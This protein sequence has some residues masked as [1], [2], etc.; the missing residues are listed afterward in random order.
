MRALDEVS[1]DL[2][3]MGN[4]HKSSLYMSFSKYS[5]YQILKQKQ[6]EKSGFFKLSE[7]LLL[8]YLTGLEDEDV[9]S[10]EEGDNEEDDTGEVKE[11]EV[12]SDDEEDDESEGEI[13]DEDVDSEE[14]E[15]SEEVDSDEGNSDTGLDKQKFSA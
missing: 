5:V 12:A 11:E 4:Y 13:D 8:L 6:K 10:N 2:E 9:D 3:R 7:F 15:D 14:E 1:S